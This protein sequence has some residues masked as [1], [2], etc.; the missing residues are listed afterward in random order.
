MTVFLLAAVSFADDPPAPPKP[1]E[2]PPAANPVA[3]ITTSMGEIRVL[4]YADETPR[5]VENFLA[6]AEGTR[7][8]KD[9][10]TGE[11]VKRPF[12]DGL[13]FHRVIADFMIQGGCP[14]GD[15]TGDAGYKFADEINAKSLGL[16]KA[17]VIDA[18]GA[19]PVMQLR[20]REDFQRNVV[21]PLFEK[22]G[23][24]SQEEL[25]KRVEEVQKR[26]D[27]LT[28]MEALENLGYSFED[29]HP[30]HAPMKGSLAMAN[31]GPNTQGSQF[32]VNL[33]D[34]PW[35]TGRHTVFGEVIGG[36]DV[37]EAIGGVKVGEDAK[38]VAEVKILSIRRL[39]PEES[40]KAVA[41]AAAKAK[42]KPDAERP[43]EEP[44]PKPEAETPKR[45]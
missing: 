30:S 18:N 6:L 16:D 4:L 29:A 1:P 20:N 22:M 17:K 41:A 28:V 2:T 26:I 19:H 31:A 7:E 9:A 23:I 25:D 27:A 21:M 42:A 33:A 45:E 14:K 35:L 8:W 15:G 10:S 37:V 24:K 13:T 36:M 43:A 34:T 38:P 11:M 3:V 12:Y 5:T 44:A 40:A 39:P 32:F